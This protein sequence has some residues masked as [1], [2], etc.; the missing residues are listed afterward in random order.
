MNDMQMQPT[1]GWL[2]PF[3]HFKRLC[4]IRL[5]GAI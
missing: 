4:I 1:F 3:G 2:Q 5:Y